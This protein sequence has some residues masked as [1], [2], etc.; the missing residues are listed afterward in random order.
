MK[1]QILSFIVHVVLI[2]CF[3]GC[4]KEEKEKADPFEGEWL[5]KTKTASSYIYWGNNHRAVTAA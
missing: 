5:I 2:L 4:K 1:K 3:A